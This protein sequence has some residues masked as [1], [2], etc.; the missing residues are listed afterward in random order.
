MA[1][2]IETF[3]P[4]DC[5]SGSA[6][7]TRLAHSTRSVPISRIGGSKLVT[8]NRITAFAVCCIWSMASS[9]AVIRFL[10]SPR[11]NGVMKVRRTAVSTSRVILSA[12]FSSWLTRWQKTKVSSPPRSMPC[13][14][15]APSATVWAWRANRSKNRSSFGR[16]VRNQRSM[17]QVHRFGTGAEATCHK[18]VIDGNR[19]ESPQAQAPNRV[20]HR[21]VDLRTQSK[22]LG[23][24]RPLQIMRDLTDDAAAERQHAGDEDRALD[25]RH[26]LAES[27]Q[28]LLC[29]DDDEGSDH[30]AEYRTKAAHQR[31][32]HDL[33]RHRHLDVRQRGVLRDKYLQRAGKSGQRSRQDV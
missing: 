27:G 21:F 31:H 15:S 22:R 26:P 11:S 9:I 32:Q 1:V 7:P 2:S 3:G 18:T 16:K 28:I 19:S 29:R 25:H 23:L 33:P 5:I 6:R 8:S 13:S 10:M 20:I 30:R 14:A 17:G 12:S 4:I 24:K